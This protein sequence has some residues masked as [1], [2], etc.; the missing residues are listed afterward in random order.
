MR[1]LTGH[2]PVPPQPLGLMQSVAIWISLVWAAAWASVYYESFPGESHIEPELRMT[3][4]KCSERLAGGTCK[5]GR[6]L[7]QP[8]A[9]RRRNWPAMSNWKLK[10]KMQCHLYSPTQKKWNYLGIYL[11]TYVQDLYV[12]NYKTMTKEIKE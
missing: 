7:S 4:G 5:R 9:E 1:A 6:H 8:E 10:F 3:G 2:L 11:T 12:E